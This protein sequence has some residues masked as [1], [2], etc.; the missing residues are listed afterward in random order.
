MGKEARS[1]SEAP[2][3][4]TNVSINE[5]LLAQAKELQV[6][7]SRA[8]EAGLAKAVADRQSELWVQENKEALDSSNEY[9]ERHG[10]PLARHRRF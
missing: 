9:V 10:L 5:A 4:A 3:R 1:V 2:K 8:A 6:N 7:V